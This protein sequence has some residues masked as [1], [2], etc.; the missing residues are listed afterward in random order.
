MSNVIAF[1]RPIS[2]Q[3]PPQKRWE[4]GFV[5]I[6]NSVLD[7]LLEA[8][9]TGNEFKLAMAICRKTYGF[10]K[11][12]DDV[13]IAQLGR[14]AGMHRQKASPAYNRLV[15]LKIIASSKGR[16]GFLTA[17]NPVE[18][19]LK[20]DKKQAAQNGTTVPK[21]DVTPSQKGTHNKQPQQT[22]NPT[23]FANA[24]D[25]SVSKKNP[26]TAIAVAEPAVAAPASLRPAASE[27]L[28]ALFH[29]HCPSLPTV[30]LLTDARR[31]ALKHR[32]TQAGRDLGRYDPRD[33]AAGL[34][35]WRK[36][37]SAVEA[38]DFLTG[39]TGSFR[40]GFDWF[41]KQTNFV[42]IIEGNY[43]NEGPA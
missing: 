11:E 3:Q 4:E 43:V 42:K 27:Q 30:K 13:T 28:L 2:A 26:S 8:D 22:I 29:Q 32:W 34:E 6:P 5:A 39:R 18:M 7:G 33:I 9:L 20:T 15:D 19:W 23:S 25:V 31:Q 40:A 16:H 10:G 12:Q 35:W 21:E 41:L 37:F 1:R 38:S 14:A 24:Q 17:F 36:F